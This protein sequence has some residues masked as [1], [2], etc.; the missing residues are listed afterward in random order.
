MAQS[1]EYSLDVLLILIKKPERTPAVP[2]A[3]GWKS[4]G[5]MLHCA[6]TLLTE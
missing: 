2:V 4:E 5:R 3:N 1:A 6:R